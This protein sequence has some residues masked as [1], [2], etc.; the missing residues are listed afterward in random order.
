MIPLFQGNP[1][2]LVAHRNPGEK[3]WNPNKGY[4]RHC[5]FLSN[6]PLLFWFIPNKCEHFGKFQAIL[7]MFCAE[8]FCGGF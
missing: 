3:R 4:K 5:D 2:F 8:L 6:E 1:L 7:W